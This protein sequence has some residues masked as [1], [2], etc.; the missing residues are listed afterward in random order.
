VP[1]PHRDDAPDSAQ[2]SKDSLINNVYF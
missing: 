1:F 2:V